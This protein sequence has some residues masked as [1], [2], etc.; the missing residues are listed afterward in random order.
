MKKQKKEEFMVRNSE[1]DPFLLFLRKLKR[2]GLF[3][4]KEVICATFV[5]KTIYLMQPALPPSH[6]MFSE[7]VHLSRCPHP[8][9]CLVLKPC[10]RLWPIFFSHA[11]DPNSQSGNYGLYFQNI[12]R[13]QPF[14]HVSTATAVTWAISTSHQGYHNCFLCGLPPLFSK[15]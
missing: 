13:T 4:F 5:H 7:Y 6:L 9:R 8:S 1:N 12:S 14:F 11:T 2:N 10:C 3:C 15:L